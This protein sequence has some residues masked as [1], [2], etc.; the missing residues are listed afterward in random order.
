MKY[1]TMLQKANIKPTHIR[2]AIMQELENNH[3]AS[4][5]EIVKSINRSQKISADRVTIY[6][7]LKAMQRQ[8]LICEFN[9][10]FGPTKFEI[11]N[12]HHQH[13]ICSECKRILKIPSQSTSHPSLENFNINHTHIIHY[14][15]CQECLAKV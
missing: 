4:A 7:N 2:C 14:G 9:T 10:G 12:H 1:A 3:T 6:R 8:N 11:S 13:A 5:D 15:Q